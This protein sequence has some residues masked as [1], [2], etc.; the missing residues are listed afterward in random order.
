MVRLTP[1]K[2]EQ[3]TAPPD[4][5]S[6]TVR[7]GILASV[8]LLVLIA[9]TK[10]VNWDEFYFLSHV[11]AFVDGR[12]D[13]PLQTFFARGFGWLTILP[14][15]EMEQVLAA[16][17]VMVGFVCVT[18]FSLYRVAENLT[19]A[20]SAN[21]AVLAFFTSGFVLPHAASFRADPIAAALLTASFAMIMTTQMKLVQVVLV[22]MM[23]ACALLVTI[24][25]ALFA[26][27]FLAA[28]LWRWGETGVVLRTLCAGILT[29]IF[30]AALYM[31]HA[32]GIA[33]APGN[34]TAT[35]MRDAATTGFLQ[36]G[37]FP[38]APYI[39]TW[40]MLSVAPIVLAVI[41]VSTV[42]NVK[43]SALLILLAAPLLSVIIYRNAFPY[44]FSFATPLM[45]IA[46]AYGARALQ[47]SAWMSRLVMI[48]VVT[49]ALQVGLS[50]TESKAAQ[51]ATIAEVHRL[52]P[53]PVPYIDDS[54][55]I[56]S[57]PSVGPF[58]STWGMRNYRQAGQPLFGASIEAHQP[59]L[60]VANKWT[61]IETMANADSGHLLP[62]DDR[63]L[64]KTYVH[65][66]GAIWLAGREITLTGGEEK[67]AMPFAGRYRV[68]AN[69]PVTINGLT[70]A[71][72]DSVTLDV[73][74]MI[75]GPSGTIVKLIW[76]TGVP[77]LEAELPTNGLYADFWV[78]QL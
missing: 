61:L 55:M 29:A 9:F 16:R 33:A 75:S 34:E 37:W 21:I 50:L 60:L 73:Q 53:E 76:D 42:R 49:G 62:Q 63:V 77:P 35:N 23:G 44:F 48:M 2:A 43:L 17:L 67:I 70:V 31:W 32:S 30:C 22:A 58:M 25:S 74:T 15:H 14:S 39:T 5:L 51:R 46:A 45:M 8:A 4:N 72:G 28:L 66:N 40:V 78:F 1:G 12:L 6:K 65:Y 36:S 27:A 20:R 47:R 57:F 59:P 68:T 10:N 26:P 38:R 69:A 56:A 54:S 3:M 41:G 7:L 52:F 64:R 71:D 18:A 13:R 19:D 11:H 24:K